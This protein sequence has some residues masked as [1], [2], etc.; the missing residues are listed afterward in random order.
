MTDQ[1]LGGLLIAVV[2]AVIGKEIGSKEKV[3][4]VVCK[5]RQTSCSTLIAEK[6]DNLADIVYKLEKSVSNKLLGL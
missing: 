2:S 3:K 5:E 6:I 4:D 1:I